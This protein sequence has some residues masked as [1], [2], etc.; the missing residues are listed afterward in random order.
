MPLDASERPLWRVLTAVTYGVDGAGPWTVQPSLSVDGTGLH[1]RRITQNCLPEIGEA[2]LVMEFGLIDGVQVDP[3]DLAG[4]HVRIQCAGRPVDQSATPTWRTVFVG[5]VE[6][7]DDYISAGADRRTG[8]RVYQ[9]LD[10][11]YSYCRNYPLN[12]HADYQ[13]PTR[14]SHGHPGYNVQQTNAQTVAGN[15]DATNGSY[16]SPD[17]ID[18]DLFLLPDSIAGKTS[19]AWTDAE[20]AQNALDLRREAGDP[21]F[22]LDIEPAGILGGTSPWE[23]SD[24]ETAWSFI[25]KV[26]D[27]RRGKGLAWLYIADDSATPDG[28]ID[29]RVRVRPLLDGDVTY[30]APPVGPVTIPGAGSVAGATVALDLEGDHRLDNSSVM[31]RDRQDSQVDELWTEGERI[32]VAVTASGYDD[33]LFPRWSAELEAAWGGGIADVAF[34]PVLQY[35]GLSRSPGGAFKNGDNSGAV[36]AE[37]RTNALGS[38]VQ[39][40][41]SVMPRSMV[42]LLPTLPFVEGWDYSGTPGPVGAA[43]LDGEPRRRRPLVMCRVAS[44][45]FIHAS[46]FK[47]GGATVNVDGDGILVEWDS[48]DGSRSLDGS[49]T[50]NNATIDRDSLTLTFAMELPARVSLAI[51]VDGPVRRRKVIRVRDSHLWIAHPGC[52]WDLDGSDE[53]AAGLAPKRVGGTLN[54]GNTGKILRDDR[55][56]LARIHYLAWEWYRSDVPRLAVDYTLRAC[57]LLPSF[58]DIAGNTIDYPRIGQVVTTMQAGGVTYQVNTPITRIVY[59]NDAGTSRISTNWTEL[60]A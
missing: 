40:G 32:Q 48:D 16:S 43:D 25:Q 29:V 50:Y 10:I 38:I 59:D 14:L 37:Y 1:V 30:N 20:A 9:C 19:R 45:R 22:P 11:L 52:I 53:T 3:I 23:V 54:D 26:L 58:A 60:D 31:I 28:A 36:S 2:D 56:A 13:I 57:V 49:W 18:V 6:W 42:R 15:K 7:Q 41:D 24:D 47:D 55:A 5:R 39:G 33:T 46:E 35:F 21:R 4:L 27:R 17:G 51:G 34:R 8:E 12:R 44:G